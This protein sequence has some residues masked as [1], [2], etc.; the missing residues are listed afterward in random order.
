MLTVALLVVSAFVVFVVVA[1]PTAA[2]SGAQANSLLYD[3]FTHDTSLN[4]SIW[5]INGPVGSVFGPH[6]VGFTI[7]PLEP[8]FS[9]KGMEI[10]QANTSEVVGTIQS[11]QNFTPPFTVTAL[12]EGTV[13]NGHTF[14]FAITSANA[15]SG[16]DIWGNLN[17]T[18]CSHLGDCGDTTVC[19]ISANSAIPPNQCYYGIDGRSAQSGGAWGS[20]SNLYATPSVNVTYSLQISVD[21]SGNARFSVSQGGQLLGQSTG[22][23]GTGPFYVIIDQGEG[24]PVA[25]PG[26]NQAYWMSVG[27][28][29]GAASSTTTSTQP[30]PAPTPAGLP[31]LVWLIIIIALGVLF[32]F[33]F[34]WYRRRGFV[35][36]VLDLRTQSPIPE[37]SVI[38]KGP[39][40]LSGF[41]G[42]DGRADFGSV[43]EGEYEISVTASGYGPSTPVTIKVKKKTEYTVKLGRASTGA[44]G[45]ADR[46]APPGTPEGGITPPPPS[47]ERQPPQAGVVR[48]PMEGAAPAVTRPESP[49]SERE[50]TAEPE[51]WGSGR[52]GQIIKTF[53]EKGA[54]SPETALTAEEL[55]LS[56]LFVRIM[57]RR[58]GRTRVFV[59]INGRYYL[60]Q[61]ALRESE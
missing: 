57:K 35:V 28:T 34:L 60:N 14:G 55:G 30:G 1:G 23:V 13:S 17:P 21:A 2:A 11:I 50:V 15:S 9:S 43:D 20:K 33:I 45:G 8:A 48:P 56:R 51:G 26:P 39:E 41:T 49:P 31:W 59:E 7:I 53:Q 54:I 36:K 44:Q 52:I 29:L 18:N 25:H 27:L 42:K 4:A 5:Q 6:E 38:A 24:A 12:V 61:E 16:V 32:F 47:L 37:A 46:T 19:G 40:K 58:K 10:A 22:Q 3:D